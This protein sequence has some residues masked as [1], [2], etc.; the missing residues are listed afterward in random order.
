MKKICAIE[1]FTKCLAKHP[2]GSKVISEMAFTGNEQVE[3]ELLGD[4]SD[5]FILHLE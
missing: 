1:A 2:H 5:G 3:G 4:I